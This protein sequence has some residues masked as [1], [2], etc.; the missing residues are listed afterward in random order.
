MQITESLNHCSTCQEGLAGW[1]WG[2]ALRLSSL[3]LVEALPPPPPIPPL[4][5]VVM[6]PSSPWFSFLRKGDHKPFN[7]L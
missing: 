4:P 1:R 5:T 6:L 2:L 3:P 7:R